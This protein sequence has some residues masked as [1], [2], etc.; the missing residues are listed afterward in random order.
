MV[1][2]QDLKKK[3]KG[4]YEEIVERVLGKQRGAEEISLEDIEAAALEIG[5]AVQN[6][7]TREMVEESERRE[8]GKRP[9]C[10]T[11]QGE[12]RKKGYR[13]KQLITRSGEVEVKREYWYCEACQAG[14]FPPG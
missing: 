7:V 13:K 12:M 2:N 10:P 9:C 4:Q 6:T 3:L 11:C 1:N 14:I 5:R 8:R